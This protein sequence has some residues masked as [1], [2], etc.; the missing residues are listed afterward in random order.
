[1]FL[2]RKAKHLFFLGLVSIGCVAIASITLNFS[3]LTMES[4]KKNFTTTWF[5]GG[6]NDF[7]GGIFWLNV[8]DIPGTITDANGDSVVCE[9]QV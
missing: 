5:V 6:G 1:M 9:K 2:Q 8:L 7:G 3:D 4:L